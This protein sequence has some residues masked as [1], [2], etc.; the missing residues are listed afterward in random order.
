[1]AAGL[2]PNEHEYFQYYGMTQERMKF[3]KPDAILMHPGPINRG[4]E[5]DSRVADGKQ[6]VILD[7]VHFG[8]AVR[9]AVLSTVM[10]SQAKLRR[11]K[12]QD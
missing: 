2:L 8:I 9:M 10:D 5:I 4:V 7:Q 11:Q 1:M 12:E 3:A 6:S